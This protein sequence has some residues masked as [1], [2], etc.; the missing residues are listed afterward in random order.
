MLVA[1]YQ[2]P[3]IKKRDMREVSKYFLIKEL[4]KAKRKGKRMTSV[5]SFCEHFIHCIDML[6]SVLFQ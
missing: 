2:V 4:E 1:R 6:S 3:Q 5:V